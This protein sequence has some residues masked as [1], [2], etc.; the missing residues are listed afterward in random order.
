MSKRN[1][2]LELIGISLVAVLIL[3]SCSLAT[4]TAAPANPTQPPA[5]DTVAP[6]PIATATT[7]TTATQPPAATATTAPAATDTPAPTESTTAQV[8]PSINAYCRKGPGTGYFSLT[9]LQK[10]TAYN[11][12]GRTD[13]NTW[14]LVQATSTIQC[15]EGDPYASLKGPVDQAPAVLVPPLPGMPTMFDRTYVCTT[16]NLKVS[17]VWAP[18]ENVTGYSIYRNGDLLASVG[19]GQTSYEDSEAP[20]GVDLQYDLQAFNDY[21]ASPSLSTNVAACGSS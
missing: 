12:V 9:Y 20:N 11:V 16:T 21:G 4:T 6:P 15:W 18:V 19:A 14:W 17:L 7:A 5:T 8:V 13:T 10:G 1:I 3:A 2:F